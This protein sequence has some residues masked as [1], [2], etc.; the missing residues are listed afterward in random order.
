MYTHAAAAAAATQT[1]T[2]RN[3]KPSHDCVTVN[4]ETAILLPAMM[5][6]IDTMP[7]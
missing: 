6:G 5:I 2:D 3:K 1:P 4:R 7:G